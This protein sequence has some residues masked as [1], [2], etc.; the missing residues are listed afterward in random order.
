MLKLCL[1]LY[2]TFINPTNNGSEYDNKIGVNTYGKSKKANV[3]RFY[4]SIFEFI[5]QT[6]LSNG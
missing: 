5:V 3:Y 2:Y 4:E 6:F 1:S